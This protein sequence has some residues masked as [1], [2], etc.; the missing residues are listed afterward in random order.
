MSKKE[1]Q[2]ENKEQQAPV[3][4]VVSSDD[5]AVPSVDDAPLVGIDDEPEEYE[6]LGLERVNFQS[7]EAQ[8]AARADRGKE[9]Q[10]DSIVEGRI[11]EARKPD[12]RATRE[13]PNREVIVR[14]VKTENRF[15]VGGVPY[16]IV[17]GRKVKVPRHVAL[18]LEEKGYLGL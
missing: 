17:S 4:G 13:D 14:P 3:A 12:K 11:I 16:Q 2:K 15:Y 9:Y 6:P 18:L 10:D 7:Y 8:A 5:P 1:T